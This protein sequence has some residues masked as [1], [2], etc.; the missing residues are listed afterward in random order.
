M[1]QELIFVDNSSAE[2][3]LSSI[4]RLA[5]NANKQISIQLRD[6]GNLR[7]IVK[8]QITSIPNTKIVDSSDIAN[9]VILFEDDPEQLSNILHEYIDDESTTLIAPITNKYF[10]NTPLFLISIPKAGTHLLFELAKAFGYTARGTSPEPPKGGEWY[11]VDNSNAHTRAKHFFVEGVYKGYFGLR[12]HPFAYSPAIFNYRNPA[13][14]V[15]SEANYYHKKGKTAFYNY[16]AHDDFNQRL[17]KLI[18]DPYLL[19]NIRERILDFLAW[20]EFGNVIP[21]S[22]EELIG[23]KGGGSDSIQK[24]LIW[25]LQLK[26]H[27]P[28]APEEFGRAIF[29]EDSD[30]FFKGQCSGYRDKFYANHYREFRVLPQDFMQK[31]GYTIEEKNTVFSSRIDEFRQRKLSV[32]KAEEWPPYIINNQYLNHRIVKYKGNLYGIPFG[33]SFNSIE[34]N[35]SEKH[36]I[37]KGDYI[38]EI[39][40]KLLLKRINK[41]GAN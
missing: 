29:K 21:A 36:G 7:E 10:K 23:S 28:G 38:D 35:E 24:K 34:S 6:T 11:Y 25:S 15:V 16:F 37:V 3:Y 27:V 39:K 2:E 31:L 5:G 18:N 8:S 17:A 32:D 1:K 26:L 4:Q 12:D 22:F 30:T 14:I 40:T 41:N 13:D 19:G 20:P 9:L 33:I